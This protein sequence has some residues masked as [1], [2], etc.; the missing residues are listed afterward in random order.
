MGKRAKPARAV[1]RR[2]RP[3]P[4]GYVY[5]TVP[6]PRTQSP[7][8]A[9]HEVALVTATARHQAPQR[10]EVVGIGIDMVELEEVRS[11]LGALG[12]RYLRRL[13]S[14]A[15]LSTCLAR[16]DPVPYLAAAFA[17]KEATL[18]AMHVEEAQPPWTSIEV[19]AGGTP[20][21]VRLIGPAKQLAETHQVEMV[22]VSTTCDS[23]KAAAVAVATGPV[24]W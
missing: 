11:S 21:V 14:E 8:L 18:K 16:K 24:D 6:H 10:G 4:Q 1:S 12:D 22:T 9:P 23:T 5:C 3:A 15:E 17:A 13:F 7:P 19:I 20:A 2:V